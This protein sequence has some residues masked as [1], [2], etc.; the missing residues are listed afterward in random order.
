MM[1]LM[2]E[3][4]KTAMGNLG[5]RASVELKKSLAEIAG[6]ERRKQSELVRIFLE[7]K[8]KEWSQSHPEI[9]LIKSTKSRN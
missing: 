1:H 7:D 2:S 6:Y 9:D 8:V 4:N 3:E 5:L